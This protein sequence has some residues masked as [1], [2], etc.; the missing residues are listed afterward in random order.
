MA[1]YYSIL[2][3]V[4]DDFCMEGAWQRP[5]LRKGEVLIHQRRVRH[6]DDISSV[7]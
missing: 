6:I 1:D 4:V 2:A 7:R 5:L 3:K